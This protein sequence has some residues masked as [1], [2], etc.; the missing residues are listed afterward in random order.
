MGVALVFD[1]YFYT[2][3]NNRTVI[4]SEKNVVLITPEQVK[5]LM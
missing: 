1:L 4:V 2:D 3:D 5:Q